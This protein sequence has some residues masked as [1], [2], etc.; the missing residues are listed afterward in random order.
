[1][2]G[3]RNELA[4]WAEAGIDKVEDWIFLDRASRAPSNGMDPMFV[5]QWLR[6]SASSLL[7]RGAV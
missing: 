1:M 6:V 4:V 7:A 2:T 5:D 3:E